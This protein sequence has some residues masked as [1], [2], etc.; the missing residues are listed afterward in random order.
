MDFRF[1]H[2]LVAFCGLFVTGVALCLSCLA[3]D[4]VVALASSLAVLGCAVTFV[5]ELDFDAID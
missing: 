2:P 4:L 5:R 1:V 3:A